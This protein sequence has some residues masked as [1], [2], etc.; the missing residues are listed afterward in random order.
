M[1]NFEWRLLQAV[2]DFID[3]YGVEELFETL[4]PG[5]TI[6]ELVVDMYNAGLLPDD[7]LEEFLHD[8]E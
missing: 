3:E 6:G 1:K 7:T 5:S 4:F 2:N 8:E